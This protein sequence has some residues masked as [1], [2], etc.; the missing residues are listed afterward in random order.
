MSYAYNLANVDYKTNVFTS[1]TYWAIPQGVNMITITAIG[2]GGG[3]AGGATNTSANARTG[4]GGGGSGSITRLTI[5]VICI[6]NSLYINIGVGG[7]GGT[8]GG[9]TG[10]N[11]GLTYVD[12]VGSNNNVTWT[13]LLVAS[14]GTGSVSNAGG[15]GGTI[16]AVTDAIYSQL[17]IWNAIGGASGGA[18]ATVTPTPLT[19]GTIVGVPITGGGGG[20]GM[21]AGSTAVSNGADIT[22]T[23]FIPTN[24]GGIGG[25]TLLSGGTNGPFSIT[26]F[27]SLGGS[28]GGG[29]GATGV[30]GGRGGDGAPGSGGGGGGAGTSAGG[31]GGV[32]GK[33]GNGLVIIQCW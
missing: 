27:Y 26:P 31:A 14:G 17:G 1:S 30:S 11:G 22:G 20:G 13:S 19:Y 21:G 33:G 4:G 6:T 24:P 15:A 5:P 23:S 18:G 16:A 29:G 7:V 12:M 25:N 28:G 9:G 10:G 8:S 2:A 3:G 32:G